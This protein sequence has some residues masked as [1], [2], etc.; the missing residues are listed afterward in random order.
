M[1]KTN[2]NKVQ[3]KTQPVP[4]SK[5][6][7]F[8]Q[9]IDRDFPSLNKKII[10]LLEY[11]NKLENYSKERSS[12]E[13][14]FLEL[15]KDLSPGDPKVNLKNYQFLKLFEES[16]INKV[17]LEKTSPGNQESPLQEIMDRKKQMH[18]E[19]LPH[20]PEI[21]QNQILFDKFVTNQIHHVE[22]SIVESKDK[23]FLTRASR[24]LKKYRVRSEDPQKTEQSS[25]L[26]QRV[27]RDKNKS[28]FKKYKFKQHSSNSNLKKDK[29]SAKKPKNPKS[30]L[31]LLAKQKYI[32]DYFKTLENF[33]LEQ[34]QRE[35][36]LKQVRSQAEN[37][38]QNTKKSDIPIEVH[39][40]LK[41]KNNIIHNNLDFLKRKKE[42]QTYSQI[43]KEK[44]AQEIQNQKQK[45]KVLYLVLQ[46]RKEKDKLKIQQMAVE[47]QEEIPFYLHFKPDCSLP[48]IKKPQELVQIP[49]FMEKPL[50]EL[51]IDQRI[52][53]LK[54]MTRV[55]INQEY[56]YLPKLKKMS[57]SMKPRKVLPN[58]SLNNPINQFLSIIGKLEMEAEKM[59][60]QNLNKLT[61]HKS[62]KHV[63]DMY[64][65][66]AL[67]KI[68]F[69]KNL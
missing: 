69:L 50:E 39:L 23:Y 2:G 8:S 46:K 5:Q 22:K 60:F 45:S 51:Q 34:S 53:K 49:S 59:Q 16:I 61:Y 36:K 30:Q 66:I 38:V 18:S 25:L 15:I 48:P 40:A 27:L 28:F 9:S 58:E 7:A 64:S 13:L 24:S 14:Y 21:F 10:D 63:E 47:N 33:H 1:V 55:A 68:E 56:N 3:S 4:N 67:R 44:N 31:V 32:Q 29:P 43:V 37:L 54:A 11:R 42:E 62:Q 17:S 12:L 35:I 41:N 57:R 6:R 20:S 19:T 65:S 52:Q 26:E